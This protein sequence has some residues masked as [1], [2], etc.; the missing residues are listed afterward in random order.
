MSNFLQCWSWRRRRR[1]RR[2]PISNHHLAI[3]VLVAIHAPWIAILVAIVRSYTILN[4]HYNDQQL[5]QQ[6]VDAGAAAFLR[7][8]TRHSEDSTATTA[9]AAR[10]LA[11][12]ENHTVHNNGTA[13][14]SSLALQVLPVAQTM[15]DLDI[16]SKHHDEV[17][18]FCVPWN[19]VLDV[20]VDE[21]W[22]HH[23]EWTVFFQD[24]THYCFERIRDAEK[25]A[26]LSSLYRLQFPTNDDDSCS[27]KSVLM[28]D[29]W[30]S[31]FGADMS[32][33]VD[34]LM[35]GMNTQRHFQITSRQPWHYALPKKF[36]RHGR[37]GTTTTT[38][39]TTAAAAAAAACPSQDMFCYFLPIS[40]CPQQVP[41]TTNDNDNVTTT[42]TVQNEIFYPQAVFLG[43]TNDD[44]DSSNQGTR[45]KTTTLRRWY[46]EYATRLQTWL[47]KSVH[48]YTQHQ[49][50]TLP[51]HTPCTVMHVRRGDVILHGLLSRR[52]HSIRD[53]INVTKRKTTTAPSSPSSPQ[54]HDHNQLER[55]I[56]LLT[57]DDNAIHEALTEF[58]NDYHWMYLNRTRYKAASGGWEQ[59]L[60]SGN[61]TLEMIILLSTLRLVRHCNSL[62]KSSSNFGNLILDEMRS[63]NASVWFINVEDGYTYDSHHSANATR[64]NDKHNVIFNA[65]N[66]QTLGISKPYMRRAPP[67]AK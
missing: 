41:T 39:T 26:F 50:R 61:A 1:R 52:Y 8:E 59:H 12:F 4:N 60:P 13:P 25:R 53:Y 34:G 16:L 18:S 48:D 11:R 22:T 3:L 42:A 62:I 37:P 43:G 66:S 35:H 5:Q 46:W 56:L 44:E 23:V 51:L 45:A 14:S 64:S 57:D 17:S 40:S 28:K 19:N 31:G 47:R 21:W 20:G 15:V 49:I 27:N 54:R 9:A 32:N 65:K 33:V 7:A 36:F 67:P 2:L 10:L 29:M 38:T 6:K 30:S 24:D 63:E 55:N 58:P